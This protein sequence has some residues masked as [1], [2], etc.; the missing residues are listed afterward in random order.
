MVTALFTIVVL[1]LTIVAFWRPRMLMNAIGV[2]A[3][4]IW[5]FLIYNQ[6]YPEGNTY[7]QTAVTIFGLCM[8]FVMIAMWI[9]EYFSMRITPPTSPEVQ[10][11]HRKK[12]VRLTQ[13]SRKESWWDD[14]NA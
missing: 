9:R 3:W 7:L 13:R 6:T 14:P 5:T 11:A 8:V 2:I 4:F 10:A 12:V 1:A